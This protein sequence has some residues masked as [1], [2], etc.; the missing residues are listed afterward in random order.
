VITVNRGKKGL[1]EKERKG[2]VMEL[3]IPKYSSI[4]AFTIRPSGPVPSMSE[5]GT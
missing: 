3:L 4:S 2:R 1:K 5:R